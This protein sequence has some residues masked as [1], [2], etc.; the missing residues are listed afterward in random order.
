MRASCVRLAL[1]L[2]GNLNHY[3][4]RALK[5]F[6]SIHIHFRLFVSFSKGYFY[7]FECHLSFAIISTLSAF[8]D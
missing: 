4:K 8:E 3:V 5:C 6:P 1:L 7:G 2:H